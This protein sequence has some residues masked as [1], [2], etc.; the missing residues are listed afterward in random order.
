MPFP[1]DIVQQGDNW[2]YKASSVLAGE[3]TVVTSPKMVVTY[4]INP[5]AVWSDGKPITST[6]FKYTWTQVT[7]GKD[8]YDTTGFNQVES[9]DDSDPATA[10]FTFK[11]PYA[12]WK[13]MFGQYGIYPS[14]ILE[15]QDRN[16][17]MK[18]GYTWSAGPWK[19]E[20]WNKGVEFTLVPN[21]AYWGTKPLVDKVVMKFIT[22]SAA[23]FQA[24]K[25]GQV[26]AI[27]P[28]PQLDAIDQIN[29]GLTGVT[30]K[31]S[32]QTG[33]S[34]ALW[35]NNS[36]A[37]FDDKAV[38]QAIG[39][40]IDRDAIVNRLFGAIGVK[41]AINS[42][43]PPIVAAFSNQEAWAMYKPDPAKVTSLMT[44]A[45]W[46]KGSDGIWA[47]GGT[48]ASFTIQ[49]TAGNK[50]RELTEQVLQSQLK[51]AG[52]EMT[53]ENQK[54]GDL[55]GKILP[56]GDFQMALYAQ[57]AT[58]L[59]PGLSSTQSSKAIPTAENGNTGN[60]WTRTNVPGLDEQLTIVDTSLDDAARAAAAKKAD[61]LMAAD[62]ITLPLDP[63][64]NIG[65]YGPKIQGDF[66]YNVIS[67]PFW[68]LNTWSLK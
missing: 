10:V 5:K 41:K 40:A 15:G 30:S 4:K 57:V 53:I 8:I 28:Q 67:G 2:V 25:S 44:G 31:I 59:D 61:D 6:D 39:Y 19:L 3:P 47:K 54:S 35:I 32:A 13:G 17:A 65:L 26:D 21:D 37:P 49:S 51:D 56:A 58:T 62:Q 23:E 16:A 64:P 22:D 33:S 18:D 29:A 55:F 12:S 60:N 68:N 38:R 14:H 42:L 24:F 36:K 63:L 45:G 52:F 34:E 48:K 66:S 46:A 11:T 9:V 43:N 27:G 20:S 1:F 50:R 7:T